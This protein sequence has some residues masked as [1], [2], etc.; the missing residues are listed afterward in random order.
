MLTSVFMTLLYSDVLYFASYVSPLSTEAKSLFEAARKG[1]A[2]IPEPGVVPEMP[3]V[4]PS[5][6]LP[7]EPPSEL[8][9]QKSN[10]TSPAT[11]APPACL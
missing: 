9:E 11:K 5:E 6:A 2:V 7:S 3:P 8:P 10:S 1:G 4:P